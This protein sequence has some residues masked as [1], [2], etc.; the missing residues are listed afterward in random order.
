MKR[1]C[2][3][4]ATCIYSFY[5]SQI[6]VN[7]RSDLEI[8]LLDSSV[9]MQRYLDGANPYT[10]KIINHTDDNYIIDPQ[11]FN[12]KTYV[13]ENN[14]LY[15]VP[16]KMI[17]K[18]YYSRD[19]E[20]CKADLLLVNKRDSLTVQLEI[21]NIDFYYKIKKTE[22]YDL[23]IQ[24]KHNEY[25]ATLLGCSKYIKDLKRKGYKIFDDKINIKIPLEP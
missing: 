2:I 25:T 8:I 21:L 10:Y 3:L 13:Y 15:D 24:S 6:K 20:D 16:E 4:I 19:L 1:T 18:G 17:P 12:G 5:L 7:T 23:E 9:S 22:K 14:E 11:G